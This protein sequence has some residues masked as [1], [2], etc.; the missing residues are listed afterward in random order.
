[1]VLL[2][3]V[4]L[5]AVIIVILIA[6]FLSAR[7]GRSDDREEPANRPSERRPSRVRT[8]DSR[9]QDER[10]AR[11]PPAGAA[12]PARGGQLPP[13]QAQNGHYPDRGD[14][15]ERGQA[16]RPR[17]YE[18]PQRRPARYDTGPTEQLAAPRPVAAG[19]RR[20]GSG[21]DTG[22]GR[23]YGGRRAGTGRDRRE[24]APAP[25]DTG[26]S[27]VPAAHDFPPGS[28]H[29]ADFPPDE[30]PSRPQ[31]GA[32]FR[33]GEFPPASPPAADASPAG[34][35]TPGSQPDEYPPEPLSAA[36]FAPVEFPADDAADFPSGE[37]PAARDRGKPVPPKAG[38]DRPDSRHRPGKGQNAG[39]GRS[40]Q[41]RKRDDDD[42]PSMDWDKL[43][44]EQYWAQLSSDKPLAAAARA[45][46]PAGE[47][48]PAPTENGQSMPA[49]AGS[50]PPAPAAG[51]PGPPSR[52]TRNSRHEAAA[53]REM[54]AQREAAQR[55]AIT[56]RLPLRP[57]QQ[58]PAAARPRN[59]APDAMPTPPGGEPS[60]A[61]LASLAGGPTG[62]SDDP[63]TS[64][65]FAQPTPDSRSYRGGRHSARASDINGS[66]RTD[67]LPIPAGYGGNGYANSDYAN[68]GPDDRTPVNGTY[69]VPDHADPGYAY[70]PAAP[71][72]RPTGAARQ[73]SWHN[74]PPRMPAQSTPAQGNPYGSFVEPTP[75]AS[76]PSTPPV[77]Y[78]DQQADADLPAYRG[79]HRG[80]QQ[81]AYDPAA[82]L[83]HPGPAAAGVPMRPSD[84]SPLP[85]AAAYP[86]AAYAGD[87]YPGDSYPG[88]GG[89][90]DE[91]RGQAPYA[92][93]YGTAGYAPGY[94]TAGAADQYGHD[95][96]GGYPAG[97][98]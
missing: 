12:R 58:P 47:P 10:A 78:Q 91:Y 85:P 27:P 9:W 49:A 95:G 63:L 62:T 98:G 60:L 74:A 54:A 29:T 96:H 77:G 3:V 8:D 48:T 59:E 13:P 45:P 42:W 51:P 33:S 25:Y 32:D 31:P 89:Y 15:P 7:L 84:R 80:Y 72:A 23:D 64:P 5:A 22:S 44:D 36:D 68:G 83:P 50:K 38:R 16:A 81:P 28:L 73:A 19:A 21:R 55:E 90:R 37:M 39:K 76:Y 46:W 40:R 69:Q 52:N 6:V 14:R 75:T 79:S 26:P 18:Q 82:S 87:G 24:A 34:Y 65:S 92:D 41:L 57:R 67:G 43:T 61:M 93:S 4:G 97:Q 53:Q 71:P 88:D 20:P 11:R 94:P 35:R 86:D 56:E 30:F 17:D 2:L 70:T 66:A 1:M